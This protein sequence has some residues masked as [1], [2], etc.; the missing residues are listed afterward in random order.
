MTLTYLSSI[1]F[2]GLIGHVQSFGQAQLLS[3][4]F[5]I[6]FI[7]YSGWGKTIPFCESFGK[8]V[9]FLSRQ[10]V[11]KSSVINH[12]WKNLPKCWCIYMHQEHIHYATFRVY[13]VPP[14]GLPAISHLLIVSIVSLTFSHMTSYWFQCLQLSSRSTLEQYQEESFLQ[15][16][17]KHTIKFC[18]GEKRQ[19]L[20]F[21]KG[22]GGEALFMNPRLEQNGERSQDGQKGS[23]ITLS[24]LRRQGVQAIDQGLQ[25]LLSWI[26]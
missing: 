21:R 12:E 18:S 17:P 11:F 16:S 5:G 15:F 24:S 23:P 13:L 8:F 19:N 3:Y 9:M 14:P 10:N 20:V 4:T 1:L 22:G 7:Q 6:I 26:I 25:M 2:V